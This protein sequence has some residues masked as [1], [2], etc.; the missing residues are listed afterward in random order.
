MV[1]IA[2]VD[3]TVDTGL[4]DTVVSDRFVDPFPCEGPPELIDCTTTRSI[5]SGSVYVESPRTYVVV[6][7][8]RRRK[9]TRR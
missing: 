8:Q 2:T 6:V 7:Q 4:T 9:M 1:G 3:C 5:V